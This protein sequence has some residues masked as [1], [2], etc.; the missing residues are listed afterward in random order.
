MRTTGSPERTEQESI[1][2]LRAKV[3]KL[4]TDDIVPVDLF[5]LLSYWNEHGEFPDENHLAEVTMDEN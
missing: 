5:K 2:G 4:M 1:R 3:V